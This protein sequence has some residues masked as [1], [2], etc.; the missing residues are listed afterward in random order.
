LNINDYWDDL[1]NV[2]EKGI[3]GFDNNN[4]VLGFEYTVL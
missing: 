4:I 1:S 3:D 2:K